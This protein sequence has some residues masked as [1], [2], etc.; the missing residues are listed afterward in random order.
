[1]LK[2]RSISIIKMV[3]LLI[4]IY[5]YANIY[6]RIERIISRD[7]NMWLGFTSE[8]LATLIFVLIFE[9]EH[10]FNL[11][12]KKGHIQVNYDQILIAGILVIIVIA[13]YLLKP[14]L[15]IN[16]LRVPILTVCIQIIFWSSLLKSVSK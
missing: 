3:L 6:P 13:V 16:I 12:I 9:L 11:F 2:C 7:F 8:V 4:F 1:M 5:T 10:I 14:G 15:A